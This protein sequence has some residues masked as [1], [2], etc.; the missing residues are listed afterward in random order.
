MQ[1]AVPDPPPGKPILVAYDGSRSART[2]ASWAVAEA[3]SSGRPLR[4]AHVLRWPLPEVDGL[5][6]PASVHDPGRA[7]QAA[8][9]LVHAAVARC[10]QMAPR[11]TSA[12]RR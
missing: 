5:D 10:R 1:P 9:N 8:S 2:A 7:R 3:A 6:L 11:S 4:L 12:E